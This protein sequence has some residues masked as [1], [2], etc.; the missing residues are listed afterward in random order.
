LSLLEA[1]ACGAI[2]IASNIPGNRDIIV[3]GVTGFL[4]E[5][6]SPASLAQALLLASRLPP[7]SQEAMQKAARNRIFDDFSEKK[8]IDSYFCLFQALLA[9]AR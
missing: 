9:K 7:S 4:V 8:M 2:S 3:N 5:P 1:C 6:N